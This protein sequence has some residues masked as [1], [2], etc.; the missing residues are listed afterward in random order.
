MTSLA[1][2]QG[3]TIAIVNAVA[4]VCAEAIGAGNYVFA[5]AESE[6]P[7]P[8]VDVE[9]MVVDLAD[10]F[11]EAGFPL[12]SLT[13]GPW[14]TSYGGEERLTHNLVGSIWRERFPLDVNTRG[15]MN[16]RDA[17]ADAFIAHTKAFSITPEIQS[18]L[19]MG[20]PGIRPRSIP[21]A[22]KAAGSGDR[23]FLTLPFTV[24]VKA[25]RPTFPKPA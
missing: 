16:D 24:Q 6:N 9:P 22:D 7:D 15:L 21:R 10:D 25:N 5:V 4:R 12:I 1:E 14:T 19:L 3:Y 23:L 18:A 11:T 13:I 17:L 8:D 2:T 20:G